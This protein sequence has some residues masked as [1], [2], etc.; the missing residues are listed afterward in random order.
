VVVGGGVVGAAFVRLRALGGGG[1]F[2]ERAATTR[3]FFR[4]GRAG[5]WREEL[6]PRQV[7]AVVREHGEVMRR[8]GYLP[9]ESEGR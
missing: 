9:D 4:H 6:T 2:R 7:E 8:F 5:G 1:G 3:R